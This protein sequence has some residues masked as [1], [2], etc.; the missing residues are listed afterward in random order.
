MSLTPRSVALLIIQLHF[1]SAM[2]ALI[3]GPF[4]FGGEPAAERTS[5]WVTHG[6]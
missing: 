3:V 2:P 4:Q 6:S 5:G 1:L